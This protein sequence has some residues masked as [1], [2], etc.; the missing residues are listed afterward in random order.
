MAH[1]KQ[2]DKNLINV[3]NDLEER[4]VNSQEA[5]QLNQ[6]KLDNRKEM[7]RDE[8]KEPRYGQNRYQ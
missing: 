1:S 2:P 7:M 6:K 4:P 3:V 5:Q 8:E